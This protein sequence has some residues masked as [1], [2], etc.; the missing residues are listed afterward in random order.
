MRILQKLT[1]ELGKTVII[2]IRDINFGQFSSI[3]SGF[4]RMWDKQ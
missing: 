1:R 4:N 3:S 2:V